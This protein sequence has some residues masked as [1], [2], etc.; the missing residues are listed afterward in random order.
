MGEEPDPYHPHLAYIHLEVGLRLGR[1]ADAGV[2][3]AHFR[4]D[5]GSGPSDRCL[6]TLRCE[7]SQWAALSCSTWACLSAA[8]MV[9]ILSVSSVDKKVVTSIAPVV[10]A[11]SWHARGWHR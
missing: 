4:L 6:G 10:F 1:E 7:G 9:R 2:A 5:H 11:S 8:V 3:Y